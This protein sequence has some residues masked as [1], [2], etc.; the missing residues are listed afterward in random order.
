MTT[1]M[2]ARDRWEDSADDQP[3]IGDSHAGAAKQNRRLALILL[4]ASALLVGEILID[5]VP[6]FYQGD[7]V[8]YLST[9]AGS[10]P[11][12]RSWLF[13][14]GVHWLL[15]TTHTYLAY[16]LIQ[17]GLLLAMA[18]MCATFL[19]RDVRS[20]AFGVITVIICL[21]PMLSIYERFYMT[22]LLA[23]MLFIAFLAALCR[24]LR[25]GRARFLTWLPVMA[26][27]VIADIFIRVAYAPIII[28]TVL[29]VAA[30]ALR[31]RQKVLGRLALVLCL[32]FIAVGLLVAANSFVFA[33]RFPGELFVNKLS[34]VMLLGTWAPAV[35]AADFRAAGIN[36]SDADVA[37][38]GLT[39]YDMRGKQIWGSDDTSARIL[40]MHRL[41]TNDVLAA[42]I[43]RAC[44]RIVRHAL[45]RNPQG[46]AR[47]Y[48]VTLLMQ[49]NPSLWHGEGF[50]I[51]TGITRTLPAGFVGWMNSMAATQITANIT[52]M[53]SP[54]FTLYRAVARVYPIL[55]GIG[56]IIALWR[57]LGR[58]R[59][60]GGLMAAAGFIAVLMTVPLY[61]VAVIPRYAIAA[62]FL[63][64]LLWADIWAAR[65]HVKQSELCPRGRCND[66][67]LVARLPASPRSDRWV[68]RKPV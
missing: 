68:S 28:L 30:E 55:L 27:C 26:A 9:T 34:G 19:T 10:M 17:A 1:E 24:G 20:P 38:L 48:A 29:I 42:S 54:V 7:S 11:P 18:I 62:V 59:Q 32:P 15:K 40:I 5:H 3:G 13:G 63:Q 43:D 46:M 31:Y 33:K 64:Y 47:V 41:G 60:L 37:A 23:C 25:A 52:Q 12:D 66:R 51:E 61:T 6:R 50:D 4:I 53:P 8:A 36:A 45:F 44:S 14:L 57:L 22:D 56:L 67:N 2:S 35:D 58:R 65:Y 21:D 16:M 49:F 39:N